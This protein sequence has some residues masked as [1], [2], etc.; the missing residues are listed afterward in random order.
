MKN[1]VW[2]VTD[3]HPQPDY[4]LLLT[5]T[6]GNKRVYDARPLLDRPLFAQLK[7]PAFFL[8]ARAEFGTVIWNDDIDIAPEH[9]YEHSEPIGGVPHA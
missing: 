6:G 1:P 2:A 9:L 7:N 5:F 4:T 8:G 3:V